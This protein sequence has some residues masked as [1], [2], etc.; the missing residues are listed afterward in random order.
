MPFITK[1]RLKEIYK[2][3]EELQSSIRAVHIEIDQLYKNYQLLQSPSNTTDM[4][5]LQEKLG[6]NTGGTLQK[7]LQDADNYEFV[8][9]VMKKQL[10]DQLIYAGGGD[11]RLI[12]T[13]QFK[14][15]EELAKY[16]VTLIHT[17]LSD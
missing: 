10:E 14:S 15:V 12:T 5:T 16:F 7:R 2:T 8:L 17:T 6:T 1:K 11:E 13:I 3:V 4:E 9:R